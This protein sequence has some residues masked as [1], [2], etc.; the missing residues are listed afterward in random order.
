MPTQK[1]NSI[2]IINEILPKTPENG[3]VCFRYNN[4]NYIFAHNS[5]SYFVEKNINTPAHF[6]FFPGF[7]RNPED[8]NKAD[9]ICTLQCIYIDIDNVK[10]N[11]PRETTLKQLN[12]FEFKPSI[13]I[14]SGYGTHVYWLL[15]SAET[16][17]EGIDKIYNV[18]KHFTN[19]LNGDKSVCS[20]G[21]LL[22]VPGSYNPKKNPAIKS[23]TLKSSMERYDLEEI[24]S[25]IP[26][27]IHELKKPKNFQASKRI[28]SKRSHVKI[29]NIISK[30]LELCPFMTHCINDAFDL[31][32]EDWKKQIFFLA[33][34]GNEGL[35]LLEEHS[36]N[37]P[38][39]NEKQ[40]Y[41]LV[42][43]VIEN[44]FQPYSCKRISE[45]T[46]N[47]YCKTCKNKHNFKDLQEVLNGI[48]L[49]EKLK[50]SYYSISDDSDVANANH[51]IEYINGNFFYYTEKQTW[52][53]WNG[54]YWEEDKTD[55]RNISVIDFSNA[56]NLIYLVL[57]KNKAIKKNLRI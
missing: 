26:K 7:I 1:N 48:L 11:I 32:L 24:L 57:I 23:K 12:E 35:I 41:D 20:R 30:T 44:G 16:T 28:K 46:Q 39:Y 5:I 3:N 15:K 33:N 50:T 22:R 53:K 19:I 10:D 55:S 54:C 38:N 25:K 42:D 49:L 45:D 2:S 13:I 29:L 31:S 56:L 17:D 51:W 37:Y 43:F 9:N 27:E 36:K 40:L 4:K 34:Q 14:D 52:M 21:H 18:A 47:K 6:Y 8:N